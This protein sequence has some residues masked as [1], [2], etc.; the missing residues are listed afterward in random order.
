MWKRRTPANTGI[1]PICSTFWSQDAPIL[2]PEPFGAGSR[3]G[4]IP[5]GPGLGGP[6]SEGPPIPSPHQ[7]PDRPG[8]VGGG[9]G[10]EH[11]QS[12]HT[13]GTTEQGGRAGKA[14]E[15]R[16]HSGTC[17]AGWR[18][19]PAAFTRSTSPQQMKQGSVW[20]GGRSVTAKPQSL[21][22]SKHAASGRGSRAYTHVKVLSRSQT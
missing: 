7:F 3:S 6:Q 2:A 5:H 1:P 17:A 22:A 16:Q 20:N 14:N 21:K 4:G 18:G 13:G 8:R 10:F 9:C 11:R 15:A 19:R 12:A